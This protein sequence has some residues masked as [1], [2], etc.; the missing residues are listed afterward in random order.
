MKRFVHCVRWQMCPQAEED[1]LQKKCDVFDKVLYPTY[2][3]DQN[4]TSVY[5][6]S[7]VLWLGHYL[8]IA[9]WYN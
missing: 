6:C 5:I 1:Y 8:D 2:D 3:I 4:T 7:L 9:W